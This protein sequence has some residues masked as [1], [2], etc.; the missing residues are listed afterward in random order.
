MDP[1][2]G[3]SPSLPHPGRGPMG[4]PFPRM[5]C[6]SSPTRRIR[7]EVRLLSERHGIWV[8]DRIE[9]GMAVLVEDGTGR[10]LDVARSLMSV[11][12]EEGTVLRVPDTEEGSPNWGLA[13][14][15]EELR[16][17]RLAEARDVLEGLKKRDPGG[18]IVL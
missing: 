12:V 6:G 1:N 3:R 15:D 2:A 16:R 4:D 7:A 17:R 18:D 11:S 14:P 10:T 5:P 8:V 13:V 9:G